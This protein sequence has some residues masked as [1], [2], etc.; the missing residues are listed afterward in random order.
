M[1]GSLTNQYGNRFKAI[2][3]TSMEVRTLGR[4]V[5]YQ[6]KLLIRCNDKIISTSMLIIRHAHTNK[7]LKN[8]L[9]DIFL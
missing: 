8:S 6:I 4:I 2:N 5:C 9:F 7:N 1:F 3:K